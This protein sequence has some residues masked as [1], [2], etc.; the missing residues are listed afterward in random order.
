MTYVKGQV[1]LGGPFHGDPL[2]VIAITPAVAGPFDA[3]T[4]VVQLALTLNPKTAEVEVDGANSEP[5]PHIIKGIVLKLQGPAR[6]RRQAEL[7]PQPDL[8]R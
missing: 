1:Y 6:L 5:I 4:V 3:G 2:S 7:H 8:L